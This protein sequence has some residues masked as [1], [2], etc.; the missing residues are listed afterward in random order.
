MYSCYPH[1][2]VHKY[3]MLPSYHFLCEII[4]NQI[5]G[6]KAWLLYSKS[7]LVQCNRYFMSL[8]SRQQTYVQRKLHQILIN[9]FFLCHFKQA[10][11]RIQSMIIHLMIIG[12]NASN[13]EC[14][15]FKVRLPTL[16]K[17]IHIPF[18]EIIDFRK[19]KDQKY[20]S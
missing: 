15:I 11:P 20:S 9:S 2:Y 8:V 6:Y 16:Q 19:V 5:F 12:C 1:T 3:N 7:M 18:E 17:S 13:I 10:W 14:I 4:F